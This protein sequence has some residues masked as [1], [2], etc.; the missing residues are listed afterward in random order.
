MV[1]IIGIHYIFRVTL[2]YSPAYFF[3]CF[4]F[5]V[6]EQQQMFDSKRKKQKK[7]KCQTWGGGSRP[8]HTH[9]HTR[10]S[11]ARSDSQTLHTA[12]T[13]IDFGRD[14]PRTG[15]TG[16]RTPPLCYATD[17]LRSILLLNDNDTLMWDDIIR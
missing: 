8:T 13:V 12:V 7:K 4:I 17:A 5:A 1:P 14:M 15:G 3:I 16:Q 9:T 2:L 10:V 11:A 6:Q